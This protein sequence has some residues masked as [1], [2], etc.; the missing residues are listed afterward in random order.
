M[1]GRLAVL[2]SKV[3]MTVNKSAGECSVEFRATV[4]SGTWRQLQA[5]EGQLAGLPQELAETCRRIFAEHSFK[6]VSLRDVPVLRLSI[7]DRAELMAWE[8]TVLLERVQ[9][10]K[11]E[12]RD[13][14]ARA[15]LVFVVHLNEGEPWPGRELVGRWLHLTGMSD[16]HLD[17]NPGIGPPQSGRGLPKAENAART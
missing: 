4:A 10:R 14:Q 3:A 9:V 6:Q 13:L 11:E 17:A 2:L 7:C 8:R 12:D 1:S 16:Q 15:R 5:E